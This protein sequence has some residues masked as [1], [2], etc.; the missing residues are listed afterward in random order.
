MDEQLPAK[1]RDTARVL[2]QR[3]NTMDADRASAA[4]DEI[5]QFRERAERAEGE[6]TESRRSHEAAKKLALRAARERNALVQMCVFS[7][8][9]A[10]EWWSFVGDFGRVAYSTLVRSSSE[11]A[12]KAVVRHRVAAL[13]AAPAGEEGGGR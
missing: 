7:N 4:A 2:E 10:D 1:L 5:E 13:D 6:L 11:E 8:G 9:R 3:G 12:A